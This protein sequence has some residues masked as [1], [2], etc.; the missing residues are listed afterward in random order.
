MFD[1]KK[2]IFLTYFSY[3]NNFSLQFFKQLKNLTKYNYFPKYNYF[4]TNNIINKQ[5][6]RIFDLSKKNIDYNKDIKNTLGLNIFN[7]F[8]FGTLNY[9]FLPL[10]NKINFENQN[11]QINLNEK[12]I[13]IVNTIENKIENFINIK[14]KNTKGKEYISLIKDIEGLNQN[15]IELVLFKKE[16][17]KIIKDLK[18]IIDKNK[19]Y[20]KLEIKKI[21]SEYNVGGYILELLMFDYAISIFSARKIKKY[22]LVEILK[23]DTVDSYRNY[24]LGREF[25]TLIIHYI[26][27]DN[28]IKLIKSK[29]SNNRFHKKFPGYLWK[30]SYGKYVLENEEIKDLGFDKYILTRENYEEYYKNYDDPKLKEFTKEAATKNLEK[31][32]SLIPAAKAIK[33]FFQENI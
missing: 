31:I 22:N 11:K 15:N 25:K 2:F 5:K 28:E 14:N 24:G 30:N 10:G 18:Q 13:A 23:L 6:N 16:N 21:D 19:I 32:I 4:K 27:E 3:L 26:F 9:K 29:S 7:R 33:E 12:N 1:Y 8:N 20:Y 17:A